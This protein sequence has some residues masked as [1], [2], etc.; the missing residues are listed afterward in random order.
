MNVS[1]ATTAELV[2]FFNAHSTKPVKKFADRK[3]A[4]R[5]V[6]ELIASMPAA[7]EL[8][9]P[10]CGGKNDITSGEIK[11]LRG[12]QHLVN[13]HIAFCHN[14]E[15]EWDMNTGKPVR[16]PAKTKKEAA[17]AIAASW[18]NKEVAARRATRHAV[19]VTNP[20]GH[21]DVFKSVREA[22]LTLNLPLGRHIKFRGELKVAGR[23]EI[24]GYTFAIVA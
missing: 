23:H 5:R 14:C 21:T 6:A 18:K 12:K 10:E 24:Q 7:H 17:A 11:Q 16:K 4:E 19:I 20:K 8:T 13:E 3:T 22:F 9:C 1:T 15:H 2:E